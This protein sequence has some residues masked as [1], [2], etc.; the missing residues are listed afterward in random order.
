[1]DGERETVYV[2]LLNEDVQ[3]WRPVDAVRQEEENVF[4]ITGRAMADEEWAFPSGSLVRCE[5]R[6]LA[7]GRALVASERASE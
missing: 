1:V 6:E 2:E 4:R 5:Y 7:D 3:V